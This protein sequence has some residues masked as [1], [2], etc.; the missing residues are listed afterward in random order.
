MLNPN[1]VTTLGYLSLNGRMT[2]N[3]QSQTNHQYLVYS[4][5]LDYENFHEWASAYPRL[6]EEE[7]RELWDE[8]LSKHAD[9]Q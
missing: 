2:A 4:L 9:P 1:S 6:H 7:L 3:L 5:D 8:Q